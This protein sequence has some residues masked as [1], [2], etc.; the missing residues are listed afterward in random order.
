LKTLEARGRAGGVYTRPAAGSLEEAAERGY[1]ESCLGDPVNG[2]LAQ[3]TGMVQ[4]EGNTTCTVTLLNA[5]WAITARHCVVAATD[6]GRLVMDPAAV[7]QLRLAFPR[8]APGKLFAIDAV[9]T[10]AGKNAGF[11][12]W[13]VMAPDSRVQ[14]RPNDTNDDQLID[15][16]A[17]RL[18][19]PAAA[20]IPGPVQI[21]SAASNDKIHMIAHYP[22]A[23]PLPGGSSLR[24]QTAGLCQVIVADSGCLL[25]GCST[26]VGAS[27]AAL[28]AERKTSSGSTEFSLIGIHASAKLEG[29]ACR[30]H[31]AFSRSL[32]RGVSVP[33]DDLLK[34]I[35]S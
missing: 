34:L 14:E 15:L 30:K 6:S 24:Q 16:V 35:S 21:T 31:S 19:Q 2:T 22:G 8:L 33:T 3:R 23:A 32:N 5:R 26:S 18:S 25:H 20:S 29:K 17:I 28:F 27:G 7:R 10:Y 1:A 12:K 4:Y 9:W 13:D 11:E